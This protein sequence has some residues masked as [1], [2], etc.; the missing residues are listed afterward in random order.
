MKLFKKA[1]ALLGAVA[2]LLTF[3]GCHKKNEVAVTVNG[4]EFTSAYYMCAFLDADSQARNKIDEKAMEDDKIDT[5]KDGYY[6]SQ[7]ID[8]KKYQEWVK[9]TAIES[10]KKIAAYKIKCD[11]NKLK[12]SNDDKL[13]VEQYAS[14]YWSNGYGAMYEPNG[15]SFETYKKY[16]LDSYYTQEYF[17]FLYGKEGKNA[18]SEDDI[19]KFLGENYLI[20]NVLYTDLS[21]LKDEEKTE[22]VKTINGYADQLKAGTLTFEDAYYKEHPSEKKEE[23]TTTTEADKDKLVQKDKFAT[24]M[25][26]DKTQETYQDEFYA[27]A[28]KMA[29]GEVKVIE[30]KDGSAIT[31]LVKGDIM[32]DPYYLENYDMTV[33]HDLKDKEYEKAIDEFVK[34]LKADVNSYAVDRFKAKKLVY[35]ESAQ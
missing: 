35:P 14:Y 33:R 16:M 11:E 29:V 17:E 5:S 8:G 32:A 19:K 18:V 21:Q 3:A 31:I 25:G 30:E 2:I 22:K 28:K 9:D 34:T 10:L 26:S 7:K 24:V 27:E 13:G 4:V 1:V 6:Y 15:V 23:T 20:A 12:I